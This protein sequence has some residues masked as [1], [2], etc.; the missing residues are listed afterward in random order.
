MTKNEIIQALDAA[1]GE[2]RATVGDTGAVRAVEA[3]RDAVAAEQARREALVEA[4]RA[5]RARKVTP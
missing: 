3:V 1:I 4:Q 2:L 5:A